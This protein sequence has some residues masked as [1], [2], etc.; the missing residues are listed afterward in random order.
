MFSYPSDIVHFHVFGCHLGSQLGSL[1]RKCDP[2][3][4]DQ[5]LHKNRLFFFIQQT[6]SIFIPL[7]VT[8]SPNL[9]PCGKSLILA[10]VTKNHIKVVFVFY[11]ADLFHFHA[12][13]CH[14]VSPF[15]SLRQTCVPD[16]CDHNSL[17][18]RLCFLSNRHSPFSFLWLSLW[19][20]TWILVAKVWSWQVRSKFT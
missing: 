14:L 13:G 18:S 1:R 7:T 4:C 3:S 10:G 16:R 6:F 11:P 12:F 17:K 19:V 5:F 2:D 20:P 8:W 9:D 15:G